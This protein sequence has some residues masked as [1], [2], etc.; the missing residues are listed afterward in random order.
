MDITIDTTVLP[1]TDPAASLEFYRDV[2]GFEVRSDVG[3]DMIAKGTHGWIMLATPYLDG[4]FDR[5]Q[6]S[7][8]E[9][10]QEPIN[11]PYACVMVPSAI[12]LAPRSGFGRLVD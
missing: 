6:A 7:G 3:S 12:P 11:Q 2:L 8:A 1:H 5:V 4:V 10:I 9:V